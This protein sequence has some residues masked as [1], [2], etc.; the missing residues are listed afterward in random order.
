VKLRRQRTKRD[1]LGKTTIPRSQLM[2]FYVL[3]EAGVDYK[4]LT[5]VAFYD[6]P[7]L[8]FERLLETYHGFSP[9]GLVSF[10]SAIP[11]WENNNVGRFP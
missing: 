2:P 8:K 1:L 10:Q 4:D 11:V 5:A 7:F 3:Q 9:R 6:K